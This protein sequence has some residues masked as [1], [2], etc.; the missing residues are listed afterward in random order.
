MKVE[1]PLLLKLGSTIQESSKVSD[2]SVKDDTIVVY[3]EKSGLC[4]NTTSTVKVFLTPSV[5]LI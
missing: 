2:K 5:P 3:T 4:S 1:L